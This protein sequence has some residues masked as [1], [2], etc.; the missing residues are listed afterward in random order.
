M[1]A[2]I[3]RTTGHQKFTRK[4]QGNKPFVAGFPSMVS[5]EI[6]P[7]G[8]YLVQRGWAKDWAATQACSDARPTAIRFSRSPESSPAL[9][10]RHRLRLQAALLFV[11]EAGLAERRTRSLL[12]GRLFKQGQSEMAA[13]LPSY[14]MQ[15]EMRAKREARR[16]EALAHTRPMD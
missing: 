11:S 15:R 7:W 14:A 2:N 3:H 4:S 10:L 13:L 16:M 1:A 12:R 8:I 6:R 9:W 5:A